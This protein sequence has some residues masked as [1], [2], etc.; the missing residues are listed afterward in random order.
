VSKGLLARPTLYLSDFFEKHKGLYYDNLTRVRTH[1]DLTQWVKFFLEGVRQTSENSIQ[2]F[3]SIISLRQKYEISILSLGKKTK[4]AK[5][6]LHYLYG[7]PVTDGQDVAEAF[8]INLST[9]LRLIED[10]VKL[11]ILRETT[12]FKRNRVFLFNK[13][14]KLFE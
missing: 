6:F 12:G 10:F 11:E 4:L 14:V 2:T 3:R 1:N 8:S 13:Y 9:A 5:N 7:K